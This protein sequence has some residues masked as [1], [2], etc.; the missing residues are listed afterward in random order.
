[1]DSE[2]LDVKWNGAPEQSPTMRRNMVT[3]IYR[4][5]KEDIPVNSPEPLGK[6]VQINVYCDAN[7]AG[8]RD[9]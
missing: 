1:M 8:N 4:G 7:Q 9:T 6:S 5:A 2:K 3:K